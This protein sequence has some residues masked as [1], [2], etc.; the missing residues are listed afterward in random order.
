MKPSDEGVLDQGAT[1]SF[2]AV[3]QSIG[4][5]SGLIPPRRVPRRCRGIPFWYE[6]AKSAKAFEMGP[7]AWRQEGRS[8]HRRQAKDLTDQLSSSVTW[9]REGRRL[10]L[11]RRRTCSKHPHPFVTSRIF[12]SALV[13]VTVIQSKPDTSKDDASATSSTHSIA[14]SV[15]S[16]GLAWKPNPL[17]D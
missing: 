3:V 16:F 5:E 17:R 6:Y 9:V 15:T 10:T 7:L 11:Y 2:H 14:R 1:I 4:A 8:P 12:D 13:Q